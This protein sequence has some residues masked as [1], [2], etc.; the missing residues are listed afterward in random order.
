MNSLRS[1]TAMSTQAAKENSPLIVLENINKSY[2]VGLQPLQVLNKIDL[3][4]NN[5]DYLSIMGPSGSGKSTLLNMI[6]MLDR[7][8]DGEY[9]LHH[10]PT[11]TLGEETRASLRRNHIGFIFQN[12]HLIPRLSA[13]ENAELPLVLAGMAP[14][15]R[16]AR[17]L[18]IFQQLGIADRSHHLPKQL[19]GGQL[20]RVAIARAMVMSPE[21]LLADEPTGNLDQTSGSEVIDVLEELNHSGITLIIVTHDRTIGQRAQRQL[22]ML[23]GKIIQEKGQHALAG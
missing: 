7:P 22:S 9:R 15:E 12:F 5:G 17:V 21:I 20:Q 13:L 8:D 2:Q 3:I 4:I 18:A 14:K 19:S 16:K 23:D 10:Q 11:A 6:G 1:S